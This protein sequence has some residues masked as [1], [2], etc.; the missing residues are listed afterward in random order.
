LQ[1]PKRQGQMMLMQRK[2]VRGDEVD[3]E[4]MVMLVV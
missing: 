4:E 1:C 2:I 3:G